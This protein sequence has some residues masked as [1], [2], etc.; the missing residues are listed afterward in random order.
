MTYQILFDFETEVWK[1]EP[2]YLRHIF[3][4]NT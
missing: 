3:E 4:Q 2:D 1:E